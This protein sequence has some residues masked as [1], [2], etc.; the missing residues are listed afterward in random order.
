MSRAD[1][2]YNG[3]SVDDI[4]CLCPDCASATSCEQ[5]TNISSMTEFRCGWCDELQRLDSVYIVSRVCELFKYSPHT[6]EDHIYT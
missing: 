5:C 4:H 1:E 6:Q 2:S 3:P